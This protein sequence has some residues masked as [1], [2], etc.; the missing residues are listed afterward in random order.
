M[1]QRFSPAFTRKKA[2]VLEDDAMPTRLCDR[3]GQ[4]IRVYLERRSS[5]PPCK[6]LFHGGPRRGESLPRAM[7]QLFASADSVLNRWQRASVEWFCGHAI[8]QYALSEV[9][10]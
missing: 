4:L 2:S 8:D 10:L 7:N 3:C 9:Q 6:L 1:M 5:H